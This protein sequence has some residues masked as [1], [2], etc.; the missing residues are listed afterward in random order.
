MELNMDVKKLIMNQANTFLIKNCFLLVG[1][2]LLL[3]CNKQTCSAEIESRLIENNSNGNAISFRLEKKPDGWILNNVENG[4]IGESR[5]SYKMEFYQDKDILVFN[6]EKIGIDDLSNALE[7]EFFKIHQIFEN[8]D[9]KK[10]PNIGFQVINPHIQ[11]KVGTRKTSHIICTLVNNVEELKKKLK[12]E[13]EAEPDKIEKLL[14]LRFSF[15]FV[16]NTPTKPVP[17]ID[18]FE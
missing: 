11:D 4:Y 7:I 6:G 3:S 18:S 16:P 14:Q 10:T 8:E 13:T 15:F 17:K 9:V 5:F 2:C 12:K 1:V